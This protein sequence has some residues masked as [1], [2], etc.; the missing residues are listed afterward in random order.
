LII[1]VVED[2]NLTM[3]KVVTKNCPQSILRAGF[4]LWLGATAMI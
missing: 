4:D 2:T 3:V 1:N